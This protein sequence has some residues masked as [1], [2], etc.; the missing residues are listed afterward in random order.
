MLRV[1]PSKRQSKTSINGLRVVGRHIGTDGFFIA[2]RLLLSGLPLEL[3]VSNSHRCEISAKKLCDRERVKTP[4]L[5][6][7][8]AVNTFL[9]ELLGLLC[10]SNSYSILCYVWSQSG[11]RLPSYDL[12]PIKA[13]DKKEGNGPPQRIRTSDLSL[14][15]A[16]LYPAELGADKLFTS[17]FIIHD[18][19][20]HS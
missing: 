8:K 9:L 16:A 2:A 12:W 13:K 7:P 11:H 15:R 14:R 3:F 5:R 4:S 1:G 10:S 20:S 17:I 18:L 19:A 6:P